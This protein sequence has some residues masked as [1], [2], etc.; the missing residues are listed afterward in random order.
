MRVLVLSYEVPSF[1]GGGGQSRQHGLLQPLAAR[2]TV[3][4]VSSGMM[5]PFGSPPRGVELVS[6]AARPPLPPPAGPRLR[7]NLDHYLHGPPW[8]HRLGA[9]EAEAIAGVL[10]EQLESF[11]PDLVQVEHGELAPLLRLLPAGIPVV[12]VLHNLLT[13]LQMQLVRLAPGPRARVANALEVAVMARQERS[14]LGAA[15]ITVVTTD[16]DRRL[17]RRL[18]RGARV[19]VVPNCVPVGYWH[20]EGTSPP[21]PV[22]VMTASFHYPPNQAAARRLLT[23]VWPRVRDTVPAARLE[24]VGQ[25]MPADLRTLGEATPGVEVVGQVD[26]ARPALHG[27][28]V[29]VA[30]LWEGSGSPLKVLEALAA[31]VPVVT[32]ARVA[33]AVGL[34]PAQGVHVADDPAGFSNALAGVLS[35]PASAAA[36][37]EA[38][39]RTVAARHDCEVAA[40]ALDRVW[41]AAV[42]TRGSSRVRRPARRHTG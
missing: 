28:R 13:I 36:G 32:T 41:Q 33:R 3:R 42:E 30:P 10:P 25:G 6:V 23:E 14:D 22:A 16:A 12:L 26:D 17:A 11:G 37:A 34:G 15:T 8:L 2:H 27:A 5:P 39:R 31:G 38:G 20:R 29:S 24:L 4:H 7:K 1:P 9:H 21:A 40:A 19:E 35:D 18:H